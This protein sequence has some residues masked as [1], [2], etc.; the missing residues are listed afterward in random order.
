MEQACFEQADLTRT[1]FSL[2]DLTRI[3]SAEATAEATLFLRCR[4]GYAEFPHAN[5][6]LAD[7]GEA[8]M[9]GANLHAISEVGTKWNGANLKKVRK[10]NKALLKAEEWKPE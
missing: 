5:L 1:N 6:N 10:T 8:D 3:R 7:F 4:L 9:E 2:A